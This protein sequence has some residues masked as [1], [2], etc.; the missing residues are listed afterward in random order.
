MQTNPAWNATLGWSDTE[1]RTMIYLD[2][3]H[4]EDVD[5]TKAIFE[6]MKEGDPA[7]YFE[8]RYRCKD[9]SYRWLS[10]VAVQEGD[11]FVCS[12]RDVTEDKERARALQSIAD[13]VK[14]REQF[15]AILSHDLRNPL[16][17][18]G[19]AVRIARREQHGEKIAAMLTAIDGSSDRMA[20]LIDV[21]MDFA[22]ARLGGGIPVDI[23]PCDNLEIS[24]ERIVDE[25]R[26]AHPDRRINTSY[27]FEGL[28]HCDLDRLDQLLSNLVANAIT[29]G[30]AR[31]PITVETKEK[32]GQFLLS[33]SNAGK[34]I[35]ETSLAKMFEP[36]VRAEGNES[37][38]GLGLGLYISS[39][40]AKA[41]HGKLDVKSDQDMT[42]F[43][44][45]IPLG[46]R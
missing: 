45:S 2:F 22:R 6:S 36:F 16:A 42:S 39:Q 25:I 26:L 38:Q 41:H 31:K 46:K 30:S 29:H 12:A 33:V 43:T 27:G 11:T 9:G 7:L 20:W 37:L 8:N 14:L 17:A 24:F 5:R 10:W 15:V 40:I 3:L 18:I 19:S 44:L 21:T 32:N 13:E 23:S 28:V 35:P 4:P 1:L 34:S